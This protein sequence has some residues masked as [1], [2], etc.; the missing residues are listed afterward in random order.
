MTKAIIMAKKELNQKVIAQLTEVAERTMKVL[1]LDSY[2]LQIEKME[3]TSSKGVGAEVIIRH[4]YRDICIRLYP[5][6]FD[7]SEEKQHRVIL[8]ELCHGLTSPLT[9]LIENA[10]DGVFVPKAVSDYQNELATSWIE[11]V[12]WQ[13]WKNKS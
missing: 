13:L 11:K 2:E 10:Q 9:N 12:V 8:H 5:V 4:E 6:F 1:F 3:E 7:S